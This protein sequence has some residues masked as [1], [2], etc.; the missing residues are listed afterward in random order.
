M[1]WM[2]NRL[3][4]KEWEYKLLASLKNPKDHSQLINAGYVGEKGIGILYNIEG[5]MTVQ[6]S[7]DK[8]IA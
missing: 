1:K 7:K 6:I 5:K 3:E 4:I 2:E 8:G